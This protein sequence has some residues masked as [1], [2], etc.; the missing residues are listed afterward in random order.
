MVNFHLIFDLQSD[1]HIGCG[2]EAGAYADA[3]C[4]KDNDGLPYIPGKS[5]KGLLKEAFLLATHAGWLEASKVAQWFG[6]ESKDGQYQQGMLQITSAQLSA[7]ERHY[8]VST[9]TSKHLFRVLQSTAIDAQTGT[10]KATS[11]RS[12]E[13]AVPMRLT[14]QISLNTTH[15][16]YQKQTSSDFFSLLPDVATLITELGGK[17]HR[18]LGKTIVTVKEA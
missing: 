4:L 2:K 9:N 6:Q 12:I 13:V 5:C 10:A 18:G 11:L 3:L 15:P 17:R 16:D 1:W 14:A 7:K 8:I